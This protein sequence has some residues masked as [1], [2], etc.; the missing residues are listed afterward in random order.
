MR[1]AV[2]SAFFGS[3]GP[4]C[5]KLAT[6]DDTGMPGRLL[7]P[8][9]LSSLHYIVDLLLIATMLAVN[10]MAVKHK[11]ISFKV[12]GAFVGTTSMFSLGCLFSATWGVAVGE[13]IISIRQLTGV[14]MMIAGVI[15]ISIDQ[16][17]H[18]II[19]RSP[20]VMDVVNLSFGGGI[21]GN[22]EVEEDIPKLNNKLEDC[23]IKSSSTGINSVEKENIRTE[24]EGSGKK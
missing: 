24:N 8:Y 21:N 18:M 17:E 16:Q 22:A 19:R 3:V 5:N 4:L 12:D 6:F 2:L 14:V 13:P 20:S 7:R 15:C 10:T 1:S 9:G 11:M 23:Q